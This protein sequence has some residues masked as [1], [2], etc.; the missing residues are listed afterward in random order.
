MS[1]SSSFIP[2]SLRGWSERDHSYDPEMYHA[3]PDPLCFVV[4]R[5]PSCVCQANGTSP[6]VPLRRAKPASP[7]SARR[8]RPGRQQAFLPS[9]SR[10][11]SAVGGLEA[12]SRSSGGRLEELYDLRHRGLLLLRS[13][14]WLSMRDKQKMLLDYNVYMAKYVLPQAPP[15]A[16]LPPTVLGKSRQPQNYQ[17]YVGGHRPSKIMRFVDKIA[18]SKYFQKATE[19]EFIKKKMEE[20]SNTPLL[21]TVEVQECRGTL[22]VNI[23]PPPTDRIWYVHFRGG[24]F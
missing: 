2:Q 22:A 12:D 16:R 1:N 5:A 23:P 15:R 17:S 10:S 4:L 14:L 19:T 24:V 3:T 8:S 18:K 6:G 7:P 11:S 21:L 20:V 9:H 13:L